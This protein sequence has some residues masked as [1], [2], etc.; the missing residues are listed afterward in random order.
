MLV[1][2]YS[3]YGVCVS[4]CGGVSIQYCESVDQIRYSDLHKPLNINE[5]CQFSRYIF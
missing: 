2:Y 3:A 5:S 1:I 4:V